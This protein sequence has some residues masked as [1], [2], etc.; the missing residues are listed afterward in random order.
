[1]GRKVGLRNAEAVVHAVYV[2][3]NTRQNDWPAFDDGFVAC[4]DSGYQEVALVALW[5]TYENL[6]RPMSNL[7]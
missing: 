7:F 6:R 2:V 1:M 4:E 3:D 5:M